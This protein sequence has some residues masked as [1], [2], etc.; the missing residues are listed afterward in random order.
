MTKKTIEQASKD[1]L[2]LE[3]QQDGTGFQAGAGADKIGSAVFNR[4][5]QRGAQAGAYGNR[6]PIT[7]QPQTWAGTDLNA[8]VHK[9]V[10]SQELRQREF[11]KGSPSGQPTPQERARNRAAETQAHAKAYSMGK[12]DNQVDQ[13]NKQRQ[14]AVDRKNKLKATISSWR[15]PGKE[16]EEQLMTKRVEEQARNVLTQDV[17][18]EAKN[19]LTHHVNAAAKAALECHRLADQWKGND[20]EDNND[21]S[22]VKM[23]RQ[24]A[25]D[26]EKIATHLRDGNVKKAA[27][28][29]YG[30]DTAAAEVIGHKTFNFLGDHA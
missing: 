20:N 30:M 21:P 19:D 8:T 28:H 5:L 1:A 24:D 27:R 26:Y 23:H 7:G 3:D 11:E 16:L 14:D 25:A 29:H 15:N 6:N 17:I 12:T 2:L 18:T 22:M 13:A 10:S 4:F 9:A